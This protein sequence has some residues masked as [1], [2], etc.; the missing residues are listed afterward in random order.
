MTD[1]K[2]EDKPMTVSMV[3]TVNNRPAEVSIEVADSLKLRGNAPDELIVVL[4]RPSEEAKIGARVAYS[5]LGFPVHF[6][7]IEGEPGWKGPAKAWNA[8]FKAASGELLYCISSE[9]VQDAGNV[10]K[11]RVAADSG[12][13]AVFGACH[14]SQ[15]TPEVVGAEPGLLVSSEMP[16][17]LGFI[18]C[19]PTWVVRRVEGFDEKFMDGFWFDDDDFFRR[20]WA[21][22]I[23]FLFD[24]SIHGVHLHHDRP[25]LTEESIDINRR[26]FLSKHGNADWA[27]LQ[28]VDVRSR[29]KLLWEHP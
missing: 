5:D 1:R 2:G 15:K 8:G 19:M 9:V 24:D 13:V 20:L 6:V 26:Y 4:D 18:V 28:R 11:A 17:P 12:H 14:N 10:E 7:E 27:K 16:R 3:L 29:G 21:E 22:G 25:D 23:D